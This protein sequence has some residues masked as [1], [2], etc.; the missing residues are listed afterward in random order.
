LG[1]DHNYNSGSGTALHYAVAYK[2]KDIIELL[3]AHG[4][5]VNARDED[6]R[7]AIFRLAEDGCGDLIQ[8]L[9]SHGAKK[10]VRDKDGMAPWDVARV[11][12]REDVIPLLLID[13]EDSPS[14]LVI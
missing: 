13:T 9:L 5:D 1:A 7:T 4:A 6:G 14:S 11:N 12:G 10:E 2:Y 3:L 8:L